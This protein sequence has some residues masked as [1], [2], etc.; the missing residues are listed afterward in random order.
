VPHRLVVSDRGLK[1][2]K[3]EYQHRRSAEPCPVPSSEALAFV[4]ARLTG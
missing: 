2:G 1:E 4:R 3:L